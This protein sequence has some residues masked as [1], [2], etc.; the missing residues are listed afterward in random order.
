MGQRE[1]ERQRVGLSITENA[2]SGLAKLIKL[3]LDVGLKMCLKTK[4]GYAFRG[5]AKPAAAKAP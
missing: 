5:K 1:L 2:K 3:K 4:H